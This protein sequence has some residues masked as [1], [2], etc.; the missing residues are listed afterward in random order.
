MSRIQVSLPPVRTRSESLTGA[1]ASIKSAAREIAFDLVSYYKGNESGQVPGNLPQPYF[2]WECGAMFGTLIDYW[3]LTGDSSY[4]EITSQGLLFQV[5]DDVNFMPANQTTEMGNDDQGFWG[6]SAMTAA[7]ANFPNPPADQPQ[8]LAL[9]QAVFNSEVGRWDEQTCSGGLRWQVFPFNTGYDYK[10]SISNGAMFNLASRLARYTGNQT[11][12]DWSERVWD[13]ITAHDLI[14][15]QFNVYDGSHDLSTNCSTQVKDQWTY[16]VGIYLHGAA[17]MYNFTNGNAT[18][19]ARVQGM[20]KSVNTFFP[21]GGPMVEIQCELSNSCDTDQ[22]SF[23]AYLAKWMAQSALLAPPVAST[24]Q[25]LLQNSA[26]KAAAQCSGNKYGRSSICGAKWTSS[27]WDGTD[28]I[29]QSMSALSVIQANLAPQSK[30]P[31]TTKTGGTSKGN[32]EAG[33]VQTQLVNYAPI[34]TK[35]VVGAAFLTVGLAVSIVGMSIWI[36]TGE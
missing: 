29:G 16:N 5:G 4:N 23:K 26:T 8:W 12:A 34:T 15:A 13:W 18:W 33:T 14:D 11:Y 3:S 17:N 1:P 19:L 30:S 31:V 27:T 2:W 10:N 24:L 7:E 36:V 25:P 22:L 21:N 20:A 28:G 6:M 9:A 32:P 35:D